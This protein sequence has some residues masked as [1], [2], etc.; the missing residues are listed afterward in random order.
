VLIRLRHRQP[1]RID[2]PQALPEELEGVG[3]LE[4]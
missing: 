1:L 3:P 4:R 2:A